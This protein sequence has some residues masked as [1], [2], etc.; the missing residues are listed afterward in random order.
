M[1]LTRR[2]FLVGGGAFLA[3]LLAAIVVLAV[4][5][6]EA[7]AASPSD[8]EV[9]PSCG[10]IT[11]KNRATV[12]AKVGLAVLGS[13]VQ[14]ATPVR[15]VLITV[16]QKLI[17]A[18]S[19]PP[20]VAVTQCPD[21]ADCPTNPVFAGLSLFGAPVDEVT[22]I[23]VVAQLGDLTWG[24]AK[25]MGVLDFAPAPGTGADSRALQ[26]GLALLA[27]LGWGPDVDRGVVLEG[28]VGQSALEPEPV[29]ESM[30]PA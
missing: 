5:S 24:E 2:T 14:N 18:C 25:S 1:P 21:A 28:A 29:G 8:I 19:W 30:E 22:W 23:E 20:P 9:S 13:D 16:L 15:D 26:A 4:F 10:R 17:P 12:T 11:I 7:A 27:A 6:K 3:I